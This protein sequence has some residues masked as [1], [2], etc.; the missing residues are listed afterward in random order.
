MSSAARMPQTTASSQQ[1]I[2]PNGGQLT[3][4]KT[5]KLPG[6]MQ[7]AIAI[8]HQIITPSPLQAMADNSL[9]TRQLHV[10]QRIA[11]NSGRAIQFNAKIAMMNVPVLQRLATAEPLQEKTSQRIEKVIQQQNMFAIPN[12]TQLAKDTNTKKK[13]KLG[14]ASKSIDMYKIHK[15][16]ARRM[17]RTLALNRLRNGKYTKRNK[18]AFTLE[19]SGLKVTIHLDSRGLGGSHPKDGG[20]SASHTEQIVKAIMSGRRKDLTAILNKKLAKHRK[21]QIKEK[22]YDREVTLVSIVS[23]NSPCTTN[24]GDTEHGC[25]GINIED[26]GMQDNINMRYLREYQ[27]DEE[28]GDKTDFQGMKEF[29][30]KA[31]SDT[32]FK[33]DES[34]DEE[35]DTEQLRG[36]EIEGT[37]LTFLDSP[38]IT[39][40]LSKVKSGKNK[41]KYKLNF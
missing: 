20:K 25:S 8:P 3:R 11:Q 10:L 21:S 24:P 4:Q 30:S 2:A 33:D 9:Q 19:V 38:A 15:P 12:I 5:D 31:K 29:M 16:E 36:E 6:E 32:D 34:S 26:L 22:N 39:E 1:K 17:F 35:I 40:N 23:S 18:L 28:E 14:K 37:A 27:G 41:G 7:E 13:K